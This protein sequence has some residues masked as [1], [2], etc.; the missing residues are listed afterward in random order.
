[1]FVLAMQD[2]SFSFLVGVGVS[3]ESRCKILVLFVR[4]KGLICMDVKMFLGGIR[5]LLVTFW[6]TLSPQ[7]TWFTPY[8]LE[9]LCY[10]TYMYKTLKASQSHY[11]QVVDVLSEHGV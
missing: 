2:K 7:I 11:K 8:S 9:I 3:K 1:M 4:C 5:E 6:P 10:A